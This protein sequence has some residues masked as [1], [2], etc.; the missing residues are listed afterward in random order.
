[1]SRLQKVLNYE[2]LPI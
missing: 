2:F 1:V